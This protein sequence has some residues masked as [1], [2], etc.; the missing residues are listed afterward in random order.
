VRILVTAVLLAC[1][2]LPAAADLGV[3][4]LTEPARGYDPT[5]PPDGANW[6]GIHPSDIYCSVSEQTGHD[7]ADGNGQIDACESIELDGVWRHVEWIGPTFTLVAL[8]GE[9]ERPIGMIMV[10]LVAA[11]TRPPAPYEYHVVY[12][13]DAYCT[14]IESFE[15]IEGV[16]QI[17]NIQDPP[18]FWGE[19]H[20]E[21]VE[22]NIHV[23]TG[24]PVEPSTW[25]RLKSF[26]SD[27]LR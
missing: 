8:A 15:P 24:S 14:I 13:P 27:L 7:D 1:L 4:E 22:T 6:H 10:E 20:V 21:A 18:E 3:Y 16:C 2:V 26:F 23:G 12:P 19:W 5:W 9:Q 17:V 11:P 25:G